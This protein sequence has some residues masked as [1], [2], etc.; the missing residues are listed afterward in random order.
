VSKAVFIAEQ[1][2][3]YHVIAL[4]QSQAARY[5]AVWRGLARALVPASVNDGENDHFSALKDFFVVTVT[6]NIIVNA[7]YSIAPI[8]IIIRPRQLPRNNIQWLIVPCVASLSLLIIHFHQ[9][10]KR[11]IT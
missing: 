7:V 10:A 4:G 9:R 5:G 6:I 11:Y 3:E 8:L 2:G 1:R